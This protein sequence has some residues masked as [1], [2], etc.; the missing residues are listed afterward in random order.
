M[1]RLLPAIAIMALLILPQAAQA[2][3]YEQAQLA[4][5]EEIFVIVVD[6]VGDGC[7][8]SPNVLKVEAELILRRSGITV[9]ADQNEVVPWL[10]IS[11]QGFEVAETADCTGN[12][13]VDLLQRQW[14]T[15]GTSGLVMF[16]SDSGYL[17]WKKS[18][19]QNRLRTAVNQKVTALANEILKARGQ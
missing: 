12:I 19:F 16:A 18:G 17:Y 6:N 11:P 9:T 3:F 15:D 4:K 13:D 10:I 7:L 8:L 14:L 2:Q 1:K 5:V